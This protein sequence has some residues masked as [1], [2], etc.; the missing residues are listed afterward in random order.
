MLTGEKS[1]LL[2]AIGERKKNRCVAEEELSKLCP[3][4][5]K[6]KKGA[7]RKLF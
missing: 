1:E 5:K 4:P 6:K 7:L 2:H 3:F